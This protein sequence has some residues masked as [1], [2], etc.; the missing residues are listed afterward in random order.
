VS[1][2]LKVGR[3]DWIAH[4]G[5]CSNLTNVVCE[6]KTTGDE[7]EM[8]ARHGCQNAAIYETD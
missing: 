1:L 8:Q 4:A 7:G 2:A 6:K 5:R 3:V